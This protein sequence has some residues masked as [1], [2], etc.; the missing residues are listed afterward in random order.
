MQMSQ[1][2]ELEKVV[3]AELEELRKQEAEKRF[4]Y[5]R[6]VGGDNVLR[7]PHEFIEHSQRAGPL[8]SDKELYE[9]ARHRAEK[10]IQAREA[11]SRRRAEVEQSIR[12]HNRRL[13]EIKRQQISGTLADKRRRE[14]LG[15]SSNNEERSGRGTG[16]R[17]ATHDPGAIEDRANAIRERLRAH[18]DRMKSAWIAKE[19]LKVREERTRLLKDNSN[20]ALAHDQSE[21]S[22]QAIS[23]EAERRVE[24]RMYAKMERT[25]R[26][27]RNMIEARPATEQERVKQRIANKRRREREQRQHSKQND[28]G[29]ER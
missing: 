14:A 21:L 9:E 1:D 19:R 23:K 8:K 16:N 22:R 12:E 29:R 27:E 28:R 15:R 18:N 2:E 3:Q 5:D 25:H 24:L 10:Q 11:K 4:L 26:A 13:D 6:S 17:Q 20:A 7:P